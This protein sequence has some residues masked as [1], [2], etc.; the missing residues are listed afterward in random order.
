MKL[1]FNFFKRVVEA[2]RTMS[3]L[4][5]ISYQVNNQDFPSH[6]SK[7]L[8]VWWIVE[9]SKSQNWRNNNFKKNLPSYVSINKNSH[10]ISPITGICGS[11]SLVVIFL[12]FLLKILSCTICPIYQWFINESK[13]LSTWARIYMCKYK[14]NKKIIDQFV[15]LQWA[16]NVQK[17]EIAICENLTFTK[18]YLN[19]SLIYLSIRIANHFCI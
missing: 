7:V 18:I 13:G 17:I 10:N 5:R 16:I 15:W 4:S 3:L 19:L 1:S 11:S 9:Q 8:D 12:F 14:I 2:I 6:R